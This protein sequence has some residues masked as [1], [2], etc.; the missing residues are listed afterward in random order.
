MHQA[1]V[2]FLNDSIDC[3]R[4]TA[5]FQG[6]F[7]EL[8]LIR[9]LHG[10]ISNYGMVSSKIRR[11]AADWTAPLVEFELRQ[12]SNEGFGELRLI[13]VPPPICGFRI[14]AESKEGFEEL[15]RI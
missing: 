5:G 14:A 13:C 15:R 6:G 7:E 11:F 1:V 10:W 8:R 3:L 9:V 12:D 2:R 4:V